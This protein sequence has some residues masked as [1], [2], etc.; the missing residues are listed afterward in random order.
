M[1][2]FYKIIFIICIIN[3]L[4]S[5]KT[6]AWSN[7]TLITE[8]ALTYS[9]EIEKNNIIYP[10]SLHS[11]L[12][13]S[14]NDLPQILQ[15]IEEWSLN[16]NNQYKYSFYPSTPEE[17]KFKS[18]AN[19]P[20]IESKFLRAIR[21]NPKMKFPIFLQLLPGD[22]LNDKHIRIPQNEILLPEISQNSIAYTFIKI[23]NS[24]LLSPLNIVATASDEP[25]YGFDVGL[26]DDSPDANNFKYHFGI[27]P[28]G[29]PNL[30]FSSQAPFHMGFY[31]NSALIYKA[32]PFL[33]KTYAEHRFYLFKE[34]AKYAF[35]KGHPYWGYRFLGWSLHYAQDLSQP[36]H[37]TPLP[38]FSSSDLI[39]FNILDALEGI[40]NRSHRRKN[41]A[42]NIISNRH[43]IYE[44]IIFNYLSYI[45]KN[46]IK[47]DPLQFVLFQNEY[48]DVNSK[49][50][51]NYLREIITSYAYKE[52]IP[53][54]GSVVFEKYNKDISS[55]L[56]KNLP[57]KYVSDPSYIFD[58]N[59]DTISL[60]K[61]LDTQQREELL[62]ISYKLLK[63]T[64]I[65]TRS[66][67]RAILQNKE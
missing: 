22:E 5:K 25:D 63:N 35:H 43:L 27:Q 23:E 18:Y 53:T 38:G 17:I 47:N 34:L 14:R 26:F 56:A 11:F 50:I 1:K 37:V 4:Q 66:I 49:N 32:A 48:H 6:Y 45:R 12:L 46:N 51:N 9:P 40:F 39:A 36:F 20:D 57:Y 21:I 10:E 28:F 24:E 60:I 2:N 3:I 41:D 15:Q 59:I 55:S 54:Y 64:G 33:T 58:F 13:E 52:T 8:L 67:V 62:K 42:I 30:V 61:N 19:D 16:R 31:H 44:Q 7:H 29:N 65:E